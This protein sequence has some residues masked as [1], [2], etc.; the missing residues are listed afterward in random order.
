MKK[1]L[2]KLAVLVG[3]GMLTACGGNN[4]VSARME[5]ENIQNLVQN[6]EFTIE[7]TW[8][9]PL[10][11]S[12]V[13]LIGNPNFIRFNGD[14]VD[15]FLPYFGV[16]HSGGVY[17]GDGGIEY[18]GTAEDL[19]ITDTGNKGEKLIKFTGDQNSEDLRFI[20]RVFKNG[21]ALTS[22]SSS[23]RQSISYQGEI[24]KSNVEME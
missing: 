7:N 1:I 13:N 18:K 6:G 9:D 23:Q 10:A 8:A 20:I 5:A 21:K 19:Q 24:K 16:R 3:I 11:G 4:A 22:V 17:G 12:R 14:Q 2:F 15:L